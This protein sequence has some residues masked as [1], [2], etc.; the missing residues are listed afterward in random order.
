MLSI[1][2]APTVGKSLKALIVKELL[3]NQ[4]RVERDNKGWFKGTELI[5][6][7][8][9]LNTLKIYPH[10]KSSHRSQAGGSFIFINFKYN[11]N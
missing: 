7:S 4:C 6:L 2:N 8:T 11:S 1:S 3:G 9:S 10:T 5:T